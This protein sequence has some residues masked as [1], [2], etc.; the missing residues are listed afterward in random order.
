V[1]P[2]GP[3]RELRGELHPLGLASRQGG[4]GLAETDVAEPDVD[5]RL[6]V[7]GDGGLV[8]EERQRL[9]ARH[10]EDVGDR[11]ALEGHLEGLA[12]VAGPPQTSH[13]T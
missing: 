12:V 6:E 1:W 13:G 11:L 8:G 3:A 10:V 2:G 7:P 4:R 9:L 5:E